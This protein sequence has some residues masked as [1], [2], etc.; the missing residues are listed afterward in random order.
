MSQGQPKLQMQDAKQLAAG[1]SRWFRAVEIISI[2][3]FWSLSAGLVWKVR[4]GFTSAPLVL[5]AGAMFGFILA[6]F[7]GGFVHWLADTWGATDLPVLGPSL[8]RPFRE[9]HVDPKAMTKHDYIETNGANCMVAVP[10][11]FMALFI[12]TTTPGYEALGLF[13][14]ASSGS[15]IFWV[16]MT[17]QIHKW[18]HLE[19]SELG[20]VLV[21]MQ[22]WH[23][24]LS[25]TH[26]DVHHT[27]PFDSYYCI[28]TG[29]LNPLLTKVRFYRHL[30]RMVTAVTGLVPR[31]DD[32]GLEA[33]LA[34]APLAP[35]SAEVQVNLPRS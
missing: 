23:L 28:T 12:P 25:P 22:R 31:R 26:H 24:I 5:A 27:P 16:M 32:I 34:I 6:D 7:V 17:N 9:H 1:Y 35:A 11:A 3:S 13:S 21:S 8:I 29:W 15:M 2:L 10:V 20:P 18:S 33:A 30:E 4:Q 19:P 14:V